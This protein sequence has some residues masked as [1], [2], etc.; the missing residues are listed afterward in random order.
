MKVHAVTT[1]VLCDSKSDPISGVVH[2][3]LKYSSSALT[4][5]CSFLHYFSFQAKVIYENVYKT[6]MIK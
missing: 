1:K 3:A 6:I 5:D 4:F 2:L